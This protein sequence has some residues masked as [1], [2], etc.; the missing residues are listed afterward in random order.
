MQ[1]ESIPC[2]CS[3]R[4]LSARGE[5]ELDPGKKWQAFYGAVDTR[6]IDAAYAML[7]MFLLY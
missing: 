6:R 4:K 7:R 3:H 2:L 1:Q 5:H